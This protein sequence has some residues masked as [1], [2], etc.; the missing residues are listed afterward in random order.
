MRELKT[1]SPAEKQKLRVVTGH[2]HHG[3]LR[4]VLPQPKLRVTLLRIR[5]TA[6]ARSISTFVSFPGIPT[7]DRPGWIRVVLLGVEP[8]PG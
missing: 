3:T 1:M 2:F 7:T 8:G 6:S 5:W 4:G